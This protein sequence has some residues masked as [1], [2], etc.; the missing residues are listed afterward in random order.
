MADRALSQDKRDELLEG[1]EVIEQERVGPGRHKAF[2][3][4][5][6]E[7]EQTYVAG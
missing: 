4:L 1:F 7:L 3:K 6:D 2:H 5:L